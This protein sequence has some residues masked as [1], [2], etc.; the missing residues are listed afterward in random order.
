MSYESTRGAAAPPGH[1]FVSTA[2]SS[3]APSA[4]V[5]LLAA[6]PA[7][8]A[9]AQAL[10]D[11]PEEIVVTSSIIPTPRREIGTAV[12]VIDGAAIELRGY[13]SLADTLR[14][15]P[16]VGVTNSGG[17][18]KNTTLRIRGEDGYRTLL[19]I[20]GV[21]ALD[22]SGPQA[23]PSFDSLIAT[24]DLERIEI[25]RGP[26]GFI[27]GADAG[28]VVNVITG[29]GG[30]DLVGRV[31]IETGTYASRKLDGMIEGGAD[32]FDYV[33]SGTR[34]E[35]DGFNAQTADTV[36]RDDDGADNTT[37]HAK[38]GWNASD[39]LRLQ[40]VVRDI[41]A[42]AEYDACFT[43]TFAPT[44]DCVQRTNQTTYRLSADYRAGK[45][46]STLAYTDLD[47]DRDNVSDGVSAFD[48]HGITK[49][50]EYTGSFAPSSA[51]TLVYGVDLQR[52]TATGSGDLERGQRGYYAEYEG[53]FASRFFVSIGARYDDGDDF[54][55]HTSGR[56]SA[57]YVS[58]RADSG[59]LKYRLSYGT[60]FRAPSLYEI[61][62]NGGPFAFPPAAST[63]LRDE[64]SRGYDVGVEYDAAN[65][66]H[67]EATYFDQKIADEIYFDLAGFSGYLQG[68]GTSASKGVE[69]GA[70][71][72]LGER[73]QLLANWTYN[74]AEDVAGDPRLRRP[75]DY[76]NVGVAWSGR[77]AR[78]RLVANYRISRDAIDVGGVA[79]DDYGVLDVS[80]AL[81]INRTLE[82]F[83][84]IENATDER[85][86]E[87]SGY[88]T[89]GRGLYAGARLRF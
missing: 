60:G 84:R 49:H 66:L 75:K 30:G 45:T 43:V 55:A 34:F 59:V 46:T 79:L 12:S 39:K 70:A 78:L 33:V 85:Y 25:L 1:A 65:G 23:A 14:T 68:I 18:G 40:L 62:Y 4:L 86:Q 76:G 81:S 38:L 67:L 64:T 44:N 83:A 17:A 35:T 63:A 41:D 10:G 82:V 19:I 72:P 61:S 24:P 15:Q 77:D 37:L 57:A 5:V 58:E 29:T 73:W 74:D 3:L 54:G 21:K 47:V 6:A 26:Q 32:S 7:P 20:D 50:L 27:Y 11:R 9:E 36:L 31:G 52:D 16:G 87:V 89:A 71:A 53:K 48:T 42:T 8:S 13:E 28:G 88:N 2:L 69:L 22:P 51:T 80:G 56:L